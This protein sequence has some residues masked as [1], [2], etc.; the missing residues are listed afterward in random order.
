[1][2]ISTILFRMFAIAFRM[3]LGKNPLS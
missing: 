3:L 2:A 1:M